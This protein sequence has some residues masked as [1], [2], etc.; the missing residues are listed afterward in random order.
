MTDENSLQQ[1]YTHGGLEAALLAALAA[2]GRDVDH[3]SPGDLSGA[4]EF[5]IGG[6]QATQQLAG[7]LALAPGM[8]LLDIGSGLGGPARHLASYGCRVVGIDLTPEFVAVANSL[9]RRMG[10]ADRVEFRQANADRLEFAD[11]SFD[12]AT[13]L[14]VGMNVPDKA[15]MFAAVHRALKPGGFFA[16][17]DVMR[18][19]AGA[20]DFPVPWSSL[21]ETSHVETPAAYRA[22]LA[23]AGFTIAAEQSR[24]E[25]ALA[26]FAAQ[27][28]RAAAGGV[29][30]LNLG[31]VLG[32]T[33]PAKLAN[34][35]GMITRGLIAPY[36]IIARRD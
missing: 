25:G 33:G 3:L 7:Q 24:K 8:C 26:F 19:E 36:E 11:G 5:H 15:A 16:V 21:P 34:M 12:G 10:M 17:Y 20:L 28:A 27:R 2:A 22:A 23:A 1:H 6:A 18:M 9:T 32:P 13:L 29:S 30:P 35:V 4:D 31:L 14:H